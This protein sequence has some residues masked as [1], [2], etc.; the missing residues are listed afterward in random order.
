MS[1]FTTI[2][3]F[4]FPFQAQIAKSSLES[5]G[6]EAF[7]LDEHTI[8]MNWLYS[9]AMGGVRLQVFTCQAE[10]AKALLSEDYSEKIPE[11][12]KEACPECKENQWE[13]FTQGKKP[14]FIVFLLL[15]FPLFFYKKTLR[16]SSCGYIK[17]SQS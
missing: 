3:R 4:D 6:I 12:K 16:C 9:N 14:A 11:D 5:A 17:K 10:E 8:N 2:A 15:G 7:V 1:K 13:I